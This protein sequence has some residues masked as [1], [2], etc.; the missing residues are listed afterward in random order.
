MRLRTAIAALALFYSA[1]SFAQSAPPPVGNWQ[2]QS[3]EIL[4]VSPNGYCEFGING[5]YTT[6]GACSW[7]ATARG[8]VLTI[9]NVTTYK[10]APVYFNVQWIDNDTISVFGDT[11]YRQK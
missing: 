11:F 3:N 4:S 5:T 9:I 1:A 10:P 7:N 2:S 8:G 6:Y